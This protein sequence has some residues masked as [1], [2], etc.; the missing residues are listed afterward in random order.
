[1]NKYNITVCFLGILYLGYENLKRWNKS[2]TTKGRYMKSLKEERRNS[3][4]HLPLRM[5]WEE[6][7]ERN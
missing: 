3:K 1:M 5:I 4:C 2:Y 7:F 6:A